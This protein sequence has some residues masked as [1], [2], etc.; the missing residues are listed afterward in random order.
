MLGG[1]V[2]WFLGTKCAR[3]RPGGG[4]SS[5]EPRCFA[6]PEYEIHTIL[7]PCNNVTW[8]FRLTRPK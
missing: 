7:H 4:G 6:S 1:V 2:A 3:L 5:R 8:K